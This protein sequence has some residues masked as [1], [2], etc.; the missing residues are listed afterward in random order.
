MQLTERETQ[1]LQLLASGLSNKGAA[2]RQGLSVKTIEVHVHKAKK[3]NKARTTPQL[4]LMAYKA[5]L[6]Q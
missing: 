6:I 3:R 4:V 5:G 2:D 1:T